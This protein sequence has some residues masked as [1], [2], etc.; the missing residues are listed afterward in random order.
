MNHQ[1][2]QNEVFV[3]DLNNNIYLINQVGRILWK[4]QLAEPINSEVFQVD[5]FRNGKL[6][7]M[8]STRNAL[9]LIDRN[10]NHVEKYPVKLRSPATNGVAVFDY[11]GNREYRIFIACEDKHVYAYNR[12]GNLLDGWEF[13]QSESEVTQPLNHFRIGD[14]DFLVFGDRYKTYILDRKGSTRVNVDTYFPQV[15]Q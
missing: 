13:G 8:F 6:Q 7:L 5:Y 11:D 9:Y 4:V 10:G 1:T 3:Q 14:R 12:E 15:G 2:G